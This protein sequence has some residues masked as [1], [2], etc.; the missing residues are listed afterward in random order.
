MFVFLEIKNIV[1]PWLFRAPQ[2]LEIFVGESPRNL[3]YARQARTNNKDFIT[4][5]PWSSHGMT[6]FF[7]KKFCLYLPR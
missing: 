6:E 5:V 4:W 7:V 2:K 3:G 1:I